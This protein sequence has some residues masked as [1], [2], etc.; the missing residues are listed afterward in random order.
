MEIV[1]DRQDRVLRIQIN[2]PQKKNAITAAMYQALAQALG[3]LEGDEGVR[4]GL[5]HGSAGIFTA[6]NDLGDFLVNPPTD[7]SAPV[8][9]FLLALSGARKPLVAAVNGPAVGLGTT[10]LLHCELVYAGETAEF[11]LPFVPLGLCPEAASSLLLP[12]IAGYQRAAEKLLLGEP[13]GAAEAR[14]MGFVNQVLPD[15]RVLEHAQVQAAKLAAMSPAALDA[16]KSLM[17]RGQRALVQDQYPRGGGSLPPP[18]RH[19][20]GP[21]SLRR[22]LRPPQARP[23]ARLGSPG[24][25]P[26]GDYRLRAG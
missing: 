1:T 19:A 22:L 7:E 4:V 16:A 26:E 10:L 24:G 14:E 20:R 18:A 15:A 5:I 23:A 11:R 2:R 3:E 21:R 13:F 12:A 6:G 8:Y 9:Q 25:R 17:K